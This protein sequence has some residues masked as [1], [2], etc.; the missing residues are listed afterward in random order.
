MSLLE[1]VI[2]PVIGAGGFRKNGNAR[3]HLGKTEVASNRSL[4]TQRLN[5]PAH[6]VEYAEPV[7][8][9]AFAD[10]ADLA[11]AAAGLCL[12]C[13]GKAGSAPGEQGFLRD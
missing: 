13:G 2:V 10:L 5:V 7:Q 3:A 1:A 8:G 9:W 11:G 12:G 6:D 4:E